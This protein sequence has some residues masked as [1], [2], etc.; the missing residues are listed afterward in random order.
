MK[1]NPLQGDVSKMPVIVQ[2]EYLYQRYRVSSDP[3]IDSRITILR[4]KATLNVAEET[5]LFELETFRKNNK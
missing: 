2:R 4:T 5:E 3:E 1:K